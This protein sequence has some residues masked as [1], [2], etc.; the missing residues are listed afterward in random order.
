MK[1]LR[2]TAIA[3]ALASLSLAMPA[4]VAQAAEPDAQQAQAS[5]QQQWQ[6]EFRA[7][8]RTRGGYPDRQS[9]PQSTVQQAQHDEPTQVGAV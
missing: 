2:L 4:V 9:G 5:G 1:Q 6:Q 3:S 7:A 8:G